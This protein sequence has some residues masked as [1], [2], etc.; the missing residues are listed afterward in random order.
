MVVSSSR[1]KAGAAG[2]LHGSHH[3]YKIKAS[4]VKGTLHRESPAITD[5]V[6]T[7][8]AD[9]T[10]RNGDALVPSRNEHLLGAIAPRLLENNRGSSDAA[11]RAT[12]PSITAWR[13]G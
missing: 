8:R 10:P 9:V 12:N 1:N 7:A 11:V 3:D 5:K 4:P 13:S 2:V 6:S